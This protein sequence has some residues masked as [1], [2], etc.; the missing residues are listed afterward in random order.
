LDTI[1][2]AFAL[3]ELERKYQ[4]AINDTTQVRNQRIL[5]NLMNEQLDNLRAK[6]KLTQYD[7]D[8]AEKLL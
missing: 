6:D 2:S 8:R 7:V 4:K 5:T 3:Q 1:N